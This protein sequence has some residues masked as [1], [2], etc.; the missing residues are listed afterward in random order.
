MAEETQIEKCRNCRFYKKVEDVKIVSESEDVE[1]GICRRSFRGECGKQSARLDST[2]VVVERR[3]SNFLYCG[4]VA[5]H[6]WCGDW[7]PKGN[8]YAAIHADY[9]EENGFADAAAEL[10]KFDRKG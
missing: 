10:R 5:Y 1:T 9:L 4:R 6:W 8:S 2:G 3:T 7:E